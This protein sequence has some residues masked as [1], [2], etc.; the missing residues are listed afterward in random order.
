MV[1]TPFLSAE[2]EIDWLH[3]AEKCLCVVCMHIWCDCMQMPAYLIEKRRT[4]NLRCVC[5]CVS[6]ASS[7]YLSHKLYINKLAYTL[8]EPRL[9]SLEIGKIVLLLCGAVHKCY[10]WVNSHTHTHK[11]M[12]SIHL[13][14]HWLHHKT[15]TICCWFTYTQSFTLCISYV[16]IVCLSPRVKDEAGVYVCQSLCSAHDFDFDFEWKPAR[17]VA[18]YSYVRHMHY[19]LNG[20]SQANDVLGWKYTLNQSLS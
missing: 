15:D 9:N 14:K 19:K 8:T 5:V 12:L 20:I 3:K 10:Y 1:Y 6:V 11:K 7:W 17:L 13:E 4:N 2:I 18:H 16:F